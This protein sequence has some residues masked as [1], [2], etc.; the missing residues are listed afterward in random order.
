MISTSPGSDTYGLLEGSCSS[1]PSNGMPLNVWL[2]LR[3]RVSTSS[4]SLIMFSLSET[5]VS[6]SESL[7]ISFSRRRLL[8]GAAPFFSLE[9]SPSSDSS[10]SGSSVS[11]SESTSRSTVLR[12]DPDKI[13]DQIFTRSS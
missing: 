13:D 10:D 1:G 6:E 9:S 7:D 5:S 12:F 8:F 2:S 11:A 4:S 3:L